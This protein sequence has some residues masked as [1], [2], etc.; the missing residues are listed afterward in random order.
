MQSGVLNVLNSDAAFVAF[1]PALPLVELNVSATGIT[2]QGLVQHMV[3]GHLL[4]LNLAN[5]NVT[6]IGTS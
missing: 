4:R 2:D 5:T 6:N 3:S 1:A